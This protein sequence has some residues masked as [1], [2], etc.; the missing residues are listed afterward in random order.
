YQPYT[1][2]GR[3]LDS[4]SGVYYYRYRYYHGQL[5]RFV[6]RDPIGYAGSDW[7]LYAYAKNRPLVIV[8]PNGTH[9]I[10]VV[11]GLAISYEAAV[12]IAATYGLSLSACFSHP[13]CRE[14]LADGVDEIVDKVNDAIDL[15]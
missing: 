14:A 13:E 5:G 3:R 7:N 4:E 9:P 2:T 12:A 6:A 10:V 11:G 1:Y 15:C 8:D